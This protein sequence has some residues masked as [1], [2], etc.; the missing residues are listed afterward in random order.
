MALIVLHYHH[1]SPRPL[2]L[3]LSPP[4]FGAQLRWLLAEGY[5]FLRQADFEVA[6]VARNSGCAKLA[7]I[8][9]D[10][11]CADVFEHA[12]PILRDLGVPSTHFVITDRLDNSRDDGYYNWDQAEQMVASGCVEFASHSHRHVKYDQIEGNRTQVLAQLEEDLQA[13]RDALFKR[14]GHV[15]SHLA[16]PWGYN[17]PEYRQ[18]AARVGFKWQYQ[19][20]FGR[21]DCLPNRNFIPRIRTDG[22]WCRVFRPWMRLW[23]SSLGASATFVLAAKNSRSQRLAAI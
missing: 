7:L 13:S 15:S 5:T 1:V 8:S 14:L 23:S 22:S 19:A 3:S 9:F 20:Y 6:A 18:I 10:D 2:A 11:G 16:W 4:A 17:P 12:F 21:A